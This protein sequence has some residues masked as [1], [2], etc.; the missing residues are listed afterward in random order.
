VSISSTIKLST[1]IAGAF[2]EISR[3]LVDRPKD[4]TQNALHRNGEPAGLRA[5]PEDPSV[6]RILTNTRYLSEA[7]DVPALDAVLLLLRCNSIVDLAQQEFGDIIIPVVIPADIESGKLV[8]DVLRTLRS[9]DQR[10]EAE[11]STLN[12]TWQRA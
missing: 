7:V 3:E 6:C 4:G 9:Q 2:D 8:W 10:L 11:V 5:V 12:H 1:N